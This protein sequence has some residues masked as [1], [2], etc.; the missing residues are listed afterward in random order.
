MDGEGPAKVAEG[1]KDQAERLGEL[2][3]RKLAERP[4][5]PALHY[6]MGVLFLRTGYPAE[7]EAWLKSAL[8]LD[9]NYAPA[10]AA[11]ADRYGQAGD[12]ARAAEHRARA[13][14]QK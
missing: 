3:S 2:Q 7:G 8:E 13:G 1:V 6:E 4:L 10:H 5:D 12:A 14:G 11:L 9:P